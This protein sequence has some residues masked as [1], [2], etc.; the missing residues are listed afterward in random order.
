MK[1]YSFWIIT[2]GLILAFS[3]SLSIGT[4][5]AQETTPEG[6]IYIVAE[7]DSLWSIALRFRVSVNDLV[8]VNDITDANQLTVGTRLVIPGLEGIPGVLTTQPLSPS[9]LRTM[10]QEL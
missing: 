9:P 7:G 1:A 6:P 3:L 2:F 5:H 4:G 8:S 10:I